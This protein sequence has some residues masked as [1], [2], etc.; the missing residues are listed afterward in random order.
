MNEKFTFYLDY[1]F[2]TYTNQEIG[3]LLAGYG[4]ILGQAPTAEQAHRFLTCIGQ[5]LCVVAMAKL[6]T[7]GKIYLYCAPHLPDPL[8][9]IPSQPGVDYVTSETVQRWLYFV[10]AQ[11][12]AAPQAPVDCPPLDPDVWGDLFAK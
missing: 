2:Q 12:A 11:Q 8:V 9:A 5:C 1:L 4:Q 3:V 6:A 10:Y 7:E